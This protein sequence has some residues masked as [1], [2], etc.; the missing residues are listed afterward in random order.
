MT[1]GDESAG[2]TVSIIHRPYG[3]ACRE[4]IRRGHCFGSVD[5]LPAP[6]PNL[7]IIVVPGSQGKLID[8]T[9]VYSRNDQIHGR[10]EERRVGK[11]GRSRMAQK[12][13]KQ[14]IVRMGIKETTQN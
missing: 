5:S 10:S 8:Y 3:A 7:S 6:H 4:P 11:E 13:E 12:H 9:Y 14:K 2:Q 1:G